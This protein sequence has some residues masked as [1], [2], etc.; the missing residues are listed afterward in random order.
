MSSVFLPPL[1]T[2]A[3][4]VVFCH[5]Y[6]SWVSPRDKMSA[7]VCDSVCTRG[8]PP[9]VRSHPRWQLSL[10][11]CRGSR[12]PSVRRGCACQQLRELARL[13]CP[14]SPANYLLCVLGMW[15]SSDIRVVF[16]PHESPSQWQRVIPNW[17]VT[18][19]QKAHICAAVLLFKA[20]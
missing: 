13:A 5:H 2:E 14:F 7:R 10:W 9:G 12:S 17:H 15:N 8:R 1:L 18:S 3:N 16:S 6:G 20:R 19:L 4:P 11:R